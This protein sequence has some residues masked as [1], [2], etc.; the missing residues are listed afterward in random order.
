MADSASG[1]QDKSVQVKLVL[2]G[3]N[4]AS[5]GRYTQ[6]HEKLLS[7]SSEDLGDDFTYTFS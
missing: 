7:T 5:I 6:V 2:L 3:K 4:A 1:S